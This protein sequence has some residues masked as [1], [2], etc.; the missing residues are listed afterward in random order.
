VIQPLK[1]PTAMYSILWLS[2][3]FPKQYGKLVLK[4]EEQC[5][6]SGFGWDWIWIQ[7]GQWI[8]I[9]WGLGILLPI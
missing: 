8:R 6:G 1:I 9:R 5:F 2:K 4:R 7:L 3:W